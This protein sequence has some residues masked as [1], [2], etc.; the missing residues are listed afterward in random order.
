MKRLTAIT[1]LAFLLSCKDDGEDDEQ[2]NNVPVVPSM[3]YSIVNIYPHDTSSFTQGLHWYNNFLYEGTGL[4]GSSRLM[5]VNLKDGKIVQETKLDNT[6]FGEGITIMNG[7]IYQLTWKNNKVLV[8]DQSTFR[9]LK[10]FNWAFEG[11]GITND[12]TNLIISTG[13]NNLYF[14]DPETF[15]L[16][17]TVGVFNENGPLGE[18]NEL[19]Y[20]NGKIYANVWGS[21]YIVKINPETG[22]VEGRIDLSGVLQKHGLSTAGT[23]VLNGIAYDSAQNRFFITGK[24]WPAL[25]ELK[26]Q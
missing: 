8:Y 19:E 3:N 10:E 2:V 7:K 26:L 13:T 17:K 5:K 4:E 20:A 16:Q 15:R 14:V 24:K 22:T 25:F 23:D 18:L 9:K 11:W 21:E 12:G 1:L 6:L